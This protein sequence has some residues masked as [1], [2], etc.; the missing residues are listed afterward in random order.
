MHNALKNKKRNR[1]HRISMMLC[2][3]ILFLCVIHTLQGIALF[4]ISELL[5]PQ[6][7]QI[8]SYKTGSGD[9]LWTIAGNVVTQGEDIRDKI[10]EI[11]RLNGLSPNHV[12][13]TGQVVKVPIKNVRDKDFRYTFRFP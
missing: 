1:T 9:T 4:Q 3:L 6:P 13:Q 10:I 8:L 7:M 12:L 2:C 11:R 5:S